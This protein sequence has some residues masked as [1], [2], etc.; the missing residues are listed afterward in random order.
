MSHFKKVLVVM[1]CFIVSLNTN[2]QSKKKTTAKKAKV[3]VQK[4]ATK[5]VETA[6]A[7]DTAV[8]TNTPAVQTE[9]ET[10]PVAVPMA[11]REQIVIT[12]PTETVK[13]D[14]V[15][16]KSSSLNPAAERALLSDSLS[17]HPIDPSNVLYRITNWRR[18]DL[19]EKM[20]QPF[21]AKNSEITKFL[22]DAVKSGVL[23]PYTSDSLNK[24]MSLE[25]FNKNL[26]MED[27]GGDGLS[28]EEKAAGFGNESGGADDGWGG[29]KPSSTTPKA[30]GN[31][32]GVDDGWGNSTAAPAAGAN[33][34][35]TA[36]PATTGT[37]TASAVAEYFARDLTTI[38]IKEDYI[39]DKQRSRAYNNI[40]SIT[41]IIPAE[42]TVRGFDVP[43]ASFK[44]KDLDKYF[45]SNPKCIWY[46]FK[47]VAQHKNMADAFDLRLFTA[48]IIKQSNPSDS[49]L[50]DIYK[51]D[52]EGLRASELLEQRLME[53]EHNLW[54]Y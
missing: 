51:G 29:A 16:T 3:T 43:V 12:Q 40:Q 37:S 52:K 53:Y 15:V 32:A 28:E 6:K 50:V 35:T 31:A 7:S 13:M 41:I 39:F 44:Y 34:G 21:F 30:A 47:N 54:E 5:S 20:N 17:V 10:K 27:T 42:K 25:T 45:R 4:P 33:K 1:L 38:E 11:E 19:K 2:A 8:N 24:P 9:T 49:Y 48:R 22:I 46:N 26:V 36:A 18:M 14:N 23:T